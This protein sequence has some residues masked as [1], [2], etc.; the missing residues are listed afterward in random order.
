MGAIPDNQGQNVFIR[1]AQ[2]RLGFSPLSKSAFKFSGIKFLMGSYLW[3]SSRAAASRHGSLRGPAPHVCHIRRR[4]GCRRAAR[5]DGAANA[6]PP[7]ARRGG[8][9]PAE[10]LWRLGPGPLRCRWAAGL[11][12]TH[13]PPCPTPPLTSRL[14]RAGRSRAE[15]APVVA[16]TA[17]VKP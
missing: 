15:L 12:P 14:N 3:V 10:H 13:P 5:V 9:G 16:A 17:T 1:R 2:N 7:R 8:S 11:P 4:P 6:S